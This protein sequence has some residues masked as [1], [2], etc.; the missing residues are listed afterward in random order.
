MIDKLTH[1]NNSNKQISCV[2]ELQ[3]ELRGSLRSQWQTLKRSPTSRN[4]KIKNQV[5]KRDLP[6][7]KA[8]P[9]SGGKDLCVDLRQLL[10]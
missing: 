3:V 4:Q 7:S 10:N 9:V 2:Q 6:T 5:P 8:L 1:V